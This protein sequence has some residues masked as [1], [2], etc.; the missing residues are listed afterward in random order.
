VAELLATEKEL[1]GSVLGP[2]TELYEN[3][4]EEALEY[5]NEMI[6]KL[7]VSQLALY[8]NMKKDKIDVIINLQKTRSQNNEL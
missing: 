3:R 2:G 5:M 1:R 4:I 7:T 8:L 6:E